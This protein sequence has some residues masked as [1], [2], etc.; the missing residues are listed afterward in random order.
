MRPRASTHATGLPRR[1]RPKPNC[2][3]MAWRLT[4]ICAGLQV[5]RARSKRDAA[6]C[7]LGALSRSPANQK[8]VSAAESPAGMA[9]STLACAAGTPVGMGMVPRATGAQ[10]PVAALCSPGKPGAV[11]AKGRGLAP[12]PCAVCS[13]QTASSTSKAKPARGKNPGFKNMPGSYRA[14]Q[15]RPCAA[16]QWAE[17]GQG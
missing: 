15:Q 10:C 17:S 5:C 2:A 4:T 8:A 6:I 9:T 3:P 16:P 12:G 14:A 7:T 11:A 13:A 1:R